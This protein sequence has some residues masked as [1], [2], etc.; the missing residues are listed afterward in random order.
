VRLVRTSGRPIPE[1]AA[2]L[3]D[4]T[5]RNWLF[6]ANADPN[7]PEVLSTDDREELNRL[8]GRVKVLEQ[9]RDILKKLPWPACCRPPLWMK[10]CRGRLLTS[11]PTGAR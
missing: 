1:I 8:R 11:A 2:E 3:G 5:L 9:E 6:A 4:Q 7:E 10:S